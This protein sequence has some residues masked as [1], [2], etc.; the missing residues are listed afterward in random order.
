MNILFFNYLINVLMLII[1][2]IIILFQYKT[3]KKELNLFYKNIF[4]KKL[5]HVV[6]YT[7]I[8]KRMSY[9]KIILYIF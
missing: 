8:M 4:K 6:V 1:S 9:I 3:L 7:R 5:H 2:F